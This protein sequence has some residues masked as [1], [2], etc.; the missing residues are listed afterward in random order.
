MEHASSIRESTDNQ[1][2]D[3]EQKGEIDL[4]EQAARA[5]NLA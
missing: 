4:V 2:S 3:K 1:L 5:S